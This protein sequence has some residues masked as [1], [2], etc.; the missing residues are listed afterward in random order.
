M[1]HKD[2]FD[3]LL[4]KSWLHFWFS[5]QFLFA[6]LTPSRKCNHGLPYQLLLLWWI[7]LVS[8][9]WVST[10]VFLFQQLLPSPVCCWE[11]LLHSPL[12]FTL[13]FDSEPWVLWLLLRREEHFQHFMFSLQSTSVFLLALLCL[14]FFWHVSFPA[15]SLK[16][17]C[18]VRVWPW[19]CHMFCW[20]SLWVCYLSVICFLLL[21]CL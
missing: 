21:F 15:S 5:L 17:V 20:T 19:F 4:L 6:T 11:Y 7:K 2:G 12:Q 14:L 18:S 3:L 1:L 16:S 10:N 8:G 9:C 13:S